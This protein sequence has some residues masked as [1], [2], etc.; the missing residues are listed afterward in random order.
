MRSRDGVMWINEGATVAPTERTKEH[1]MSKTDSRTLANDLDGV[2]LTV[3]RRSVAGHGE[4]YGITSYYFRTTNDL[5]KIAANLMAYADEQDRPEPLTI[6]ISVEVAESIARGINYD[7]NI[8]DLICNAL[9]QRK[10]AS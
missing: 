5:R 8:R 9:H 1:E 7:G 10:A 4:A 6:E 2:D 3:E